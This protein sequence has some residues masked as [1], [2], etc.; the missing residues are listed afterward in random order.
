MTT[1]GRE[2]NVSVTARTLFLR[3]FLPFGLG[4]FLS[5]LYRVVNAVVGQDLTTELQLGPQSL[6]LLTSVYF[7]TFAS[8]QLPLGVL[9][10]RFG[11]RKT[12][13]LLLLFAGCGALLFAQADGITGLTIGR[14]LI[15]FGVSACLM[16]AFKAYTQWFPLQQLP[17]INGFQMAAGG[18][19]ALTATVPVEAALQITDWRTVFVGLAIATFFS[20]CCIFFLVPE[21]P[22]NNKGESLQ[23]LL[24]GTWQVF[25]S[26]KFWTLAPLTTFSQAAYLSIQGLWAGPWLLHVGGYDRQSTADILFFM[27]VAMT[28][29][30]LLLGTIATRLQKSGFSTAHSGVT[31]MFVF[32]LV[33]LGLIFIPPSASVILWLLFGFFGTSGIIAYA[34]LTHAFPAHLSGRVTTGINL[35]VFVAAFACQWAIGAVIDY[36][37]TSREQMAVSGF[38][39]SFGGLLLLEI[40]GLVFFFLLQ[41]KSIDDSVKEHSKCR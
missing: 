22:V 21:K 9:L 27:A 4:Y 11:P 17:L 26:K 34:A 2:N 1:D 30:F 6:G 41:E 36:F 7:I 16:A 8:F 13:A 10:D 23:A 18:L 35:L 33:Q 25:T 5:Y 28:S 24:L 14:G 40:I 20:S 15:G 29:G 31:G 39:W 37:S 3:V 19:G 32:I 38:N 12:E